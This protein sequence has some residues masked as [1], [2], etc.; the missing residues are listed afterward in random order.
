[1]TRKKKITICA[2]VIVLV[3]LILLGFYH[4][5]RTR[6]GSNDFDTY[7]FAGRLAATGENL[8]T[9]EAFRTT[10][11]PFLYLPLFAVLIAP[12]TFLGIRSAAVIWYA[13]AILAFAGSF[14]LSLRL[15]A[16]SSDIKKLLS[17]RPYL[18]K[19]ASLVMVIVIWLDNVSLAQ[20]DVMIFFLIILAL[21]VYEKGWKFASGVVLAAAAVIKIYPFYVLLYFLVKRRFKALAGALTGVFLFLLVLPWAVLG[22]N[23]FSDSMKSWA[24]MRVAPYL[25]TGGEKIGSNYVKFE[26]QLKPKN[27][28]PSA[29][30]TRYL[31]RDDEDIKILKEEDFEYRIYWPHPFTPRQVDIITK[32]FLLAVFTITFFNLDYRIIR[33]GSAC[34]NLEYSVIFLSMLLLFPMVKSHTL[35]PAIFPV[36]VFNYLK[37]GSDQRW[38]YGSR[39]MECAFWGALVLYFLQAGEYM[40]VLGTGGLSVLALWVLFICMLRKE[41]NMGVINHAP[42]DVCI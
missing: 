20:V 26:A 16:P 19:T 9:D 30:I 10:I 12:L 5:M 17:Q 40:Q 31:L 7:Y 2:T 27:Q 37:H 3:V 32:I 13:L 8:Y 21:F 41:K 1:M 29:I 14:Y 11:S 42:T 34:L 38:I 6:C 18:L 39:L 23:N 33:T 22:Q 28:A 36:I 24:A 15:I 4:D 35:A 25:E